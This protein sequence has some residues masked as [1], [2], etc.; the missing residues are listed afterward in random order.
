MRKRPYNNE[1][2]AAA[3]KPPAQ[4]KKLAAA[5][6]ANYRY[7]L[8]E[9]CKGTSDCSTLATFTPAEIIFQREKVARMTKA[10]RFHWLS[11]VV[12]SARDH[13]T[14]HLI[15]FNHQGH[16]LCQAAFCSL[17]YIT[18]QTLHNHR[19]EVVT[20]HPYTPRAC[21]VTEPVVVWLNG[22]LKEIADR[23][24]VDGKLVLP[25]STLTRDELRRMFCY[26]LKYPATFISPSAFY[27]LLRVSYLVFGLSVLFIIWDA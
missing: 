14:G 26:E 4:P 12:S 24:P 5:N 6:I 8:G 20:P 9:C 17:F 3:A 18:P 27:G 16:K 11:G 22:R 15:H 21:L 23:S 2:R 13:A 1:K 25:R 10:Q 19:S 7:G